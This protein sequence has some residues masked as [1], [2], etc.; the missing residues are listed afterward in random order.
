M[1][2]VGVYA[3]CVSALLMTRKDTPKTD[4][5]VIV[6]AADSTMTDFIWNWKPRVVFTTTESINLNVTMNPLIFITHGRWQVKVMQALTDGPL[7]SSTTP[8]M[9][10]GFIIGIHKAR[11]KCHQV[12]SEFL[13]IFVV[14][15]FSH[16]DT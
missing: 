15:L 7:C 3:S 16:V 9:V 4:P 14:L 12:S 2:C 10:R 5:V 11:I 8:T 1:L 6:Y 13:D